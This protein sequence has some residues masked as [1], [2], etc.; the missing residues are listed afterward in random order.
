MTFWTTSDALLSSQPSAIY[1]R[2]ATM[3]IT[4]PA[5][6]MRAVSATA[7]EVKLQLGDFD[8]AFPWSWERA[9]E[10]MP[11]DANKRIVRTSDGT[12]IR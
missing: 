7:N 3:K 5:T 12:V 11:N 6:A 4:K 10:S 2:E 8:A 1:A 9:R